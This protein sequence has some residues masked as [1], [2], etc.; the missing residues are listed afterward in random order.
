MTKA[1]NIIIIFVVNYAL[2][3][4][5]SGLIELSVLSKKAKEMQNIMRTS[6]DMALDQTQVVGDF[7]LTGSA[8]GDR[9]KINMPRSNGS[10]FV[11]TDL[12]GGLYNLNSEVETNTGYIFAKLYIN[13]DFSNLSKSLD[14]V[15]KPVRYWNASKTGFVWYYIPT[16]SLMG[17]DILPKYQ[18][19]VGVKDASGNYVSES[20]AADLMSVY[21]LNSHIKLSGGKQYFNTPVNLGITYL[22]KDL[23]GSLFMNNIDLLMR[24]K[25]EGNLNNPNGG[26]GILKG[27]TYANKVQGDLQGSNPINNGSFSV[28]RGKQRSSLPSVRSFDG[29]APNITYKVI[30]MYNRSNEDLLVSLFGGNKGGFKFKA[31]YLK[32]LDA[33]LRNPV[34][35]A[36]YITKPIV[37]AKVTFYMDVV[38]PYFT[39]IAREFRGSLGDKTTNFLE[40]KPTTADGA[41][42]TRRLAY[43]RFFAVTP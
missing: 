3:I 39:L 2:M 30:D 40:V 32:S 10:G 27:T 20:L 1:R 38:V 35:N 26:N 19:T 21:G 42:G 4:F 7:L 43:T 23:L 18:S 6:A 22:N 16:I 13:S 31:D 37:V 25:Y 14:A 9:Y 29:V 5:V 33:S 34:T 12:F 41:H 17:T 36:P 24:L 28:L 8:T 15:R 11:E